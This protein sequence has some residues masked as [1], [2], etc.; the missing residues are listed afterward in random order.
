MKVKFYF[1]LFNKN[2]IDRTNYLN[3]LNIYRDSDLHVALCW[4]CK[5]SDKQDCRSDHLL[6]RK[7]DLS[8]LLRRRRNLDG[9]VFQNGVSDVVRRM[10]RRFVRFV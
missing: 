8:M 2:E 9:D 7:N 3:K 4:L 5:T 10:I 1:E 6:Q